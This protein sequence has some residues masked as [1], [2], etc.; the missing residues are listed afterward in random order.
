VICKITPTCVKYSAGIG[1][2]FALG[3]GRERG[4]YRLRS[5]V[6]LLFI[7]VLG[8]SVSGQAATQSSA[9]K[10][11]YIKAVYSLPLSL[12]P[13]QMNDTASLVAGNLLYDGL[14]R[15]SPTL[16]IEGALAEDWSTSADGR[17]ITFKLRSGAKFHDGSQVTADDVVASLSRALSAESKVKK[18]YDCIQGIKAIDSLTVTIQLTHPFPPFL[19]VLAGATAKILPKKSVAAKNFFE[20]P[21][22]SGP[23]RFVDREAS[24]FRRLVLEA[25][26]EHYQGKPKLD[27]LILQEATEAQALELAANGQIHDLANWPLTGSEPV[28][29][30]GQKITGPVAATWIIGLNTKIP[31]FN[32]LKVRQNFRHAVDVDGFREKFFSDAIPSYGYVPPGLPGYLSIGGHVASKNA[33]SKSRIKI[34]IPDAILRHKE[35]K[36][37]LES[38]LRAKGWN[39]EVVPMAWDKLMD[40]YVGKVHQAFLVSMNMDYPDA[41]FLLRNFQSTNS[42]NFSGLK[43]AKIDTLLSEA[44]TTQDRK[45]RQE[46]Y[47]SALALVDEAAVT[48]NL[49][50]PRANIWA[51][52]CVRGL[53]PNI[54]SDVYIDYAQVSLA[55]N[56]SGVSVVAR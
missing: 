16:K 29:A 48:V 19:S 26:A 3:E 27:R 53:H 38:S 51:S 45:K 47:R 54:L 23:F 13:V 6:A 22:G 46:L 55:D 7:L 30:K 28:F 50:H 10:K 44:R 15:F 20:K 24:P 12:D 9:S 21:I 49:F 56:C 43:D 37:F 31:P 4:D 41:E 40:G 14:L 2:V 25:F 39:V 18:L 5:T 34:V 32:S 11:I 33:A 36:T 35:M 42:D 17:T 1:L 52:E 8:P